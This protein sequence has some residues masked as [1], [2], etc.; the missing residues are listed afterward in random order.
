MNLALLDA[1]ILQDLLDGLHGATEEVHVQ[2][3]ELGT[4]ER[5]GE[6][7]T[8]LERL[9]F[10]ASRLLGGERTLGLLDLALQLTES[11]EVLGNVGAGLLLVLLEHV[12]DN[13]VVEVL[14]TEMGVTGSRK[15]S[16]TPSSI[17]RS[18]TSKVP[19]PRS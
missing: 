18:E 11:A 17:E 2:L 5:L 3:L 16:K 14:A 8:A 10:D 1:G 7:V 13:T 12:L 4:G 15:T 19:P 9:D 6:V